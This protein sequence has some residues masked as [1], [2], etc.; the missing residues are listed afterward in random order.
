MLNRGS[1][2]APYWRGVAQIA[3]PQNQK[4]IAGVQVS[5]TLSTKKVDDVIVIKASGRLTT[6]APLILLRDTIRRF[7][8]DGALKF[9][10]DLN[11]VSHIDSAALGELVSSYTS[12]RSRNGDIKLLLQGR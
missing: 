6:G 9:V 11:E 5:F 8:N 12:L 4:P 3:Y 1:N 10:L 2:N 7:S